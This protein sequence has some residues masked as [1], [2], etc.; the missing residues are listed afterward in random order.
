MLLGEEKEAWS[1]GLIIVEDDVWIG[2]RVIIL[3]G[4]RIGQGAII[5]A[6]SVVT[7]DVPP[8]AI[9]GGDP[10]R[11]IK[12]RFDEE[13][14]KQLIKIDFSRISKEFVLNNI[15]LLYDKKYVTIILN[16]LL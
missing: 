1:K 9:V 8:Y 3:S 15:D 14:V 10:A 2:T 6:G 12:Y 7:K 11:V 16:K 5:G 4:I 13:T